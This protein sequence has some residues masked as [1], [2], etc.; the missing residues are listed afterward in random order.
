MDE[1][2][3]AFFCTRTRKRLWQA[4]DDELCRLIAAADGGGNVLLAVD[5][6]GHRGA[7][8][9]AGDFDSGDLLA[10]LRVEGEEIGVVVFRVEEGG[11]IPFGDTCFSRDAGLGGEDECGGQDGEDTSVP[12]KGWEVEIFEQ[13]VICRALSDGRHPDVVAGVEVDGGEAAVGWLE[14]REVVRTA[15]TPRV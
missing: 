3:R 9:V 11:V 13:R 10:G 2:H 1:T 8:G 6:V 12:S 14:D 15:R 5:F 7:E 4:E